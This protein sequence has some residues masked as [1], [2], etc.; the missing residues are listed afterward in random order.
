LASCIRD[1]GDE[2]CSLIERRDMNDQRVVRGALLRSED[3][4]DGCAI[5]RVRT[6][7]VDRFGRE[8]HESSTAKT[9]GGT[10]NH[11]PIGILG[12]NP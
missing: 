5:E 4:L 6:E 9:R 10:C 1:V 2:R 8:G 11:G 3:A 7:A 12:I